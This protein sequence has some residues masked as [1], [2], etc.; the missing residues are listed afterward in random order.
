MDV[1]GIT[2][3]CAEFIWFRIMRSGGSIKDRKF[4]EQLSDC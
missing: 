2:S 1:K 4:L 3:E